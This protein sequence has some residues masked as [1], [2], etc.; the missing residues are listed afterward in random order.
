M[1]QLMGCFRYKNELNFFFLNFCL[2]L[3]YFE[4][5]VAKIMCFVIFSKMVIFG[6]NVTAFLVKFL[7]KMYTFIHFNEFV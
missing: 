4:Q 7:L 6:Q 1:Q 3:V 5:K 2:L